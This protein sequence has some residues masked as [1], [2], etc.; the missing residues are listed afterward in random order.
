MNP[1]TLTILV[2]LFGFLLVMGIQQIVQSRNASVALRM[3]NLNGNKPDSG[4][5]KQ[6]KNADFPREMLA[7]FGKL[8]LFSRMGKGME[9]KLEESDIPLSGGEFMVL[10]LISA[11]ISAV[12]FFSI[13]MNVLVAVAGGAVTLVIPFFL[14]KHKK[15]KR[16]I[17]FNGQICD[18]LSIMSN[19]LRAGF[20][21]MQSMDMVR[22][23]MPDPI[24]KEFGRAFLE[25]NLGTSTEE[26]LQNM[27]KRVNSDDLD[28]LVTAVLIQRQVGGNLA[29][30]L[31]NI[32]GTIRE[33]VRLKGEIKALTAQGR[34]SGVII[35]LLPV[36]LAMF[37]LVT[38][39]TYLMELVINPL[40][41]FMILAAVMGEIIGFM[42]I[43]KIVNID[44]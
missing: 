19:S 11:L 17:S 13:T 43:K 12:L 23:E 32:G 27:N 28:L 25:I 16:L 39:P 15:Q 22:K 4:G 18:A 14:V 42:F 33:R 34:L 9:K 36:I 30:V 6:A 1:T 5:K 20:S 24:Q 29:E 37:M 8:R 2:F 44:V 41:R 21:F 40:G 35:G 7:S 10:D 38:N 3:K 26:A 31:D